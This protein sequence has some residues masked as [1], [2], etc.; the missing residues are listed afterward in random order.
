M[1]TNPQS[2]MHFI[3]LANT[4]R[5]NKVR[6]CS[7]I[8]FLVLAACTDWVIFV[9]FFSFVQYNFFRL[10][11]LE[12]KYHFYQQEIWSQIYFAWKKMSFP[13]NCLFSFLRRIACWFSVVPFKMMIILLISC[14]FPRNKDTDYHMIHWF[15]L[16]Q[17]SSKQC[18]R[19]FTSDEI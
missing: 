6:S 11:Y 19:H 2:G 10:K 4:L 15:S 12:T 13:S 8:S 3:S 1:H 14:W 16:F 9:V 5:C 18:Q 7:L 17:H